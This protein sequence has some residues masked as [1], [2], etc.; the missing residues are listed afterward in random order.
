MGRNEDEWD[1]GEHLSIKYLV[2]HRWIP[3]QL[4]D[5]VYPVIMLRAAVVPPQ[6]SNFDNNSVER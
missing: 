4:S 5:T 1:I 6:E 2:L 3:F